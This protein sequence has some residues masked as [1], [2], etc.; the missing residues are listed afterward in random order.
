MTNHR[1]H[2]RSERLKSLLGAINQ[3]GF[4]AT[5][6]GYNRPGFSHA[7]KQVRDWFATQLTKDGLM[8]TQ[9]AAG[10][11][12]GRLGPIDAP[13]IMVG[14]H[15]DTVPEGGAFDGALGVAIGLE[16]IRSIK[17]KGI[18]LRHP[19]VVAATSDEEGRFGG[20]LGSQ[21]ISGQLAQGW[22][23]EAEDADG[24]K[25][26]D[27]MR[28]QGYDPDALQLSAWPFGSIKAFLELHVEQ[29]PMLETATQSIGIVEG[30]S[31]VLVLSIDLDGVA[32]HSGTTPME[33]RSDAFAGLAQIAAGIPD[34]IREIGTD[35]SRITIGKVAIEPN[36]PHTIP[37]HASFTVIIRDL[38]SD[39]MGL[40]RA[41]LT[42][43]VAKVC[44][45]HRLTHRIE[46]R[47]Y[48]APTLLDPALRTTF[49]T[50]AKALGL[51]HQIMPS[52]AG[53]DAQTMQAFCPSGL[54]FVPSKDGISH[55]PEEWTDWPDIE[56]GAQL[57]LN[58]ILQLA[59]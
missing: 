26:T 16:C 21:T 4:N 37:G 59:T 15:L 20:M 2:I 58:T 35:Q 11:V 43:N 13:C 50:E 14:S 38:S 51:E 29:G 34:M 53:H 17:E 33:L 3:F 54:I 48:I 22:A 30:V 18:A 45:Q 7:D 55:A 28:H 8:V 5:T 31:G 12:F 32:N 23:E 44:E 41:K 49:L 47:S 6:G 40:L 39:V 52:G 25:L 24:I 57:M 27:A 10:N 36:F 56:K 1:V 9:D 42:E 19:I 46:E